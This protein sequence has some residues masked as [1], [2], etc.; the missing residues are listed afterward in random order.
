[1]AE[2]RFPPSAQR[3]A[4]ARREGRVVYS[5]WM[6]VGISLFVAALVA[7][8]SFSWVSGGSLIQ[9]RELQDMV[10]GEMFLDAIRVAL[11]LTLGVL[12][13]VA[14]AAAAAHLLQTRFAFSL[15]RIVSNAQRVGPGAFAKRLGDGLREVPCGALRAAFILIVTVPV[16]V[17]YVGGVEYLQ[18]APKAVVAEH[19]SRMLWALVLRGVG[20]VLV[21]GLV[22]YWVTRRRFFKDNSMS[23]ED[24]RQESRDDQGDPHLRS[25]R[26]AE[27]QALS[28]AD[29][30]RRVKRSKVVVIRRERISHS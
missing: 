12:L 13:P 17:S 25:A 18:A 21:V 4:K 10:P 1:M 8:R 3:L 23:F 2:K 11:G 19:A 9:S 14:I 24:L 20:V 5:R 28:M 30:E 7:P 22:A 26:K 27:A 6:S 29:L 16:V 15:V